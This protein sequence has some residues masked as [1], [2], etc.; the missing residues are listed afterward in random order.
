MNPPKVNIGDWIK[1]QTDEKNPGINGYVFNVSPEGDRLYVGYLQNNV[2][3]IKEP[4]CWTGAFWKFEYDGPN[5]SYLKGSD[6][7]VVKKGP[8]R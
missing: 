6:A 8:Y 3:P 5:G 7:E 2:K 4:V 1:I